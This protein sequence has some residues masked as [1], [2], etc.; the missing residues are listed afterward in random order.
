MGVQQLSKKRMKEKG[1]K[2]KGKG[3]G[4]E[5]KRKEKKRKRE[6]ERKER[7]KGKG[8]E[9]ERKKKE[10]GKG[11]EREGKGREK[12]DLQYIQKFRPWRKNIFLAL[13]CLENLNG[14]SRRSYRCWGT[15]TNQFRLKLIGRKSK[16]K[17]GSSAMLLGRS[18]L[19]RPKRATPPNF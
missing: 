12:K 6:R 14:P 7:E 3:K 13:F 17:F 10:K 19:Q 5:R 18:G 2:E 4:R 15:Q 9:R 11:K 8:K 1:K 16:S